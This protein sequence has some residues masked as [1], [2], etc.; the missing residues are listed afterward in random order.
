MK[1]NYDTWAPGPFF[2]LDA[3]NPVLA[4]DAEAE[5][6]CPL[7]FRL[8]WMNKAVYNPAATRK[9]GKV[10]LIFRGE[11]YHNERGKW[12]TS[13][14][15][16]AESDDGLHFEKHPAPVL[17]PDEDGCKPREWIGGVEDPRVVKAEDGTYWVTY[18]GS[19]GKNQR[20]LI[21]SSRDLIH[22]T[23][24]GLAF[25]DALGGKYANRWSKSAS[26]IC[27]RVGDEFIATRLQG[28]Y[29]MYWGE[30]DIYLAHSYDLSSWT[31][32]E[33]PDGGTRAP[34]DFL[35]DFETRST[36]QGLAQLLPVLRP[37]EG[38]FDSN[39]VEPGPPAY[40]TEHGIVFI[41]NSK[42]DCVAGDAN[43]PPGAYCPAAVLLDPNDPGR[44][45][46]RG[47][48]PLLKADRPFEMTGRYP[49]CIFAQG[50][51]AD[52]DKLLL[53]YGSADTLLGVA[54]TQSAPALIKPERRS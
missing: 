40:L 20:L 45:L 15:G 28:K 42:N 54:S 24:H 44:V 9:D 31:P 46:A 34:L 41:Y 7:S 51:V 18:T 38:Q 29:W 19:D 10:C 3:V 43:Y 50:L 13:R 22:W 53:Y 6:D 36:T 17:F 1:T 52:G 26:I 23:K 39:L 48:T 47:E 12:G 8:N 5:F 16:Y 33:L 32:V 21:A 49:H 25:R 37:R 4:P 14:I 11:D 30:A 27:R 35:P 2:K